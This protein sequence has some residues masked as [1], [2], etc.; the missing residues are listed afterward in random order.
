M[1]E[2]KTITE[3]AK[4]AGVSKTAV[5]MVINGRGSE[6]RISK[7]TQKKILS[8]VKKKNFTPSQVAR[9]FRL[10]KTQ[11]VGLIVPDL[12]N[13]FFSGISHEIEVLA[14][15]HNHQVLIACSDDDENTELAVIKNLHARRVDGLIIASVMKKEQVTSDIIG[16]NIPVVYIDRRIENKNVSW[17]A[18]DNFKGTYDIVNHMCKQGSPE[19]CYLGGLKNISTSRNR[20]K[21]YR[22]A[23]EDNGVAFRPK[24]V[25]QKDYTIASGYELAQKLYNYRKKAPE[26]IFTASLT[27]LQGA[28]K[29]ITEKHGEIPGSMQ[30]STY[31]DHPFLDYMSVKICSVRQDTH[32]ISQVAT[33]MIFD[34]LSGK[35]SVQQKIIK[36]KMI[37]R[38]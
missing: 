23:L 26:S 2:S 3:I 5:S 15:K 35:Q 30:I 11:T 9:G 37:I 24:L 31:D 13:W 34:A 14:R 19:I 4:L 12:T 27:L 22:Q 28:L 10:K 32:K 20:L 16:L 8:I 25:L 36:P 6:Y 7:K 17:V 33:E 1:A 38:A 18:S 21:G 29:F